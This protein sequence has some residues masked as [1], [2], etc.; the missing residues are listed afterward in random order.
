MQCRTCRYDLS[1]LREHRCPEC[2]E[3][4]DPADPET[5][6]E[7]VERYRRVL[8]WLCIV[9]SAYPLLVLAA[10]HVTWLTAAL[11]LGHWPRPN[12]DDPGSI[13]AAVALAGTATALIL[14]AGCVVLPL[15]A[16]LLV[17]YG[18]RSDWRDS[19]HVRDVA[20][21][22]FLSVWTWCLTVLLIRWDPFDAM[23][24]F[25]D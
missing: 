4:F 15:H 23:A 22:A 16:A 14:M 13:G 8:A 12:Q 19:R 17:A 5:T 6:Y 1:G 7:G 24:W 9:L 10:V 25:L 20:A 3:S 18:V 2:G 11:V 21:L